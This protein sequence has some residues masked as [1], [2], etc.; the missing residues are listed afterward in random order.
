MV[1]NE[2]VKFEKIGNTADDTRDGNT[3][4]IFF[5]NTHI[6]LFFLL[7][8][9]ASD[10]VKETLKCVEAKSCECDNFDELPLNEAHAAPNSKSRI[11]KTNI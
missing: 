2:L 10:H 6:Q 4:Y 7:S 3:L 8:I 1:K 9:L 5:F 11:G